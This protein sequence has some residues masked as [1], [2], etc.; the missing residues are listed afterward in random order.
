[1]ERV[2][3]EE[4]CRIAR[5][6]GYDSNGLRFSIQELLEVVPRDLSMES[7]SEFVD[8]VTFVKV[9]SGDTDFFRRQLVDVPVG[10]RVSATG[11]G[12][13]AYIALHIGDDEIRSRALSLFHLL[14]AR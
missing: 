2:L 7:L 5:V 6:N 14:T 11:L 1:M 3:T 13:L 12:N 9:R 4:E 8:A 10:T